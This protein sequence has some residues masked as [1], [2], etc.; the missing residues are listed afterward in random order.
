MQIKSTEQII[1]FLKP[2]IGHIK[3]KQKNGFI[4]LFDLKKSY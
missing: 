3:I 2:T 4:F 1:F